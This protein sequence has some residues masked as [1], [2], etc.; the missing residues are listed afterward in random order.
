MAAQAVFAGQKANAAS[1][2]A[3][4]TKKPKGTSKMGEISKQFQT[5]EQAAQERQTEAR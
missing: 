2:A 4:Q 3:A 5:S 1:V